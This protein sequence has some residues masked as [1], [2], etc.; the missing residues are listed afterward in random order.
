MNEGAQAQGTAALLQV[1]LHAVR[2]EA[3]GI[4][5]FEFRRPDG[6]DL[7]TFAAGA[8]VDL[9]LPGGLSRSYSLL[10]APTESNHYVVA[11]A[12]DPA[13]RGSRQMHEALPVG[14]VMA[15]SMPRN[16]FPLDE[17][18]PHSVLIAG[19]IGITPIWA[20]MQR[21]TLL[22]ASCEV[23]YAARTRDV[24]AFVPQL[25]S[26]ARRTGTPLSL[27][28]DHEP[29]GQPLDLR[30]IAAV[31]APDAHLY[32]CGPKPMLAAFEVACAQRNPA[33][34]H[35]EYF[36]SRASAA[37]EGGYR[38]HLARSQRC[39]F[40]PPGRTLLDAL[41]DAGVDLPHSCMQGTCGACETR[42]LDGVPDHRDAILTEAERRA[43]RT[44][45]PCCSGAKS[46]ELV[47]E[48]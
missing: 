9:C 29:G 39:L 8:H 34:V 32:C 33:T 17:S 15:L 31:A 12:L 10:N 43:G 47:L 30:A 13:G 4:L 3:E 7:P 5:S 27:Y 18:A 41:L 2:W 25:E 44:M 6:R 24:A 1:R 16:H 35:L 40:V 46:A 20:M 19:G 28:F 14:T 26:L 38:V 45:M 37:S 11:V 36:A 48:L 21:L 22:R 23:H 42:V